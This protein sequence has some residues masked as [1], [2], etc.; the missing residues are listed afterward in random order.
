MPF[1]L[2]NAPTMLQ[3]LVSDVLCDM[4]NILLVFLDGILIFS[5]SEEV[6]ALH[7]CWLLQ[8][9]PEVKAEKCESEDSVVPGAC[10]C[11]CSELEKVNVVVNW[12][13]PTWRKQFQFLLHKLFGRFIQ[14]YSQAAAALHMLYSSDMYIILPQSS[15]KFI[16]LHICKQTVLLVSGG[17]G[18]I[19][20]A[21]DKYPNQ[22]CKSG[23]LR[24]K[25]WGSPVPV[26][27]FSNED[28]VP[29]FPGSS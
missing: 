8:H 17:W 9:P 13:V 18:S 19:S 3:D 29:S 26:L 15:Q 4:L 1:G 25:G 5:Q 20:I 2:T 7:I 28:K 27:F 10:H 14:N 11:T 24:H 6:H 21:F 16:H 23:H 22:A 12:P